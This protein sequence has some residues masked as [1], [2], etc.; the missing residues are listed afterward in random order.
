MLGYIF[1]IT[2]TKRLTIMLL[3]EE[4]H[5]FVFQLKRTTLEHTLTSTF[6]VG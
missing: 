6:H 1:K 4:F 5:S 2:V 3:N